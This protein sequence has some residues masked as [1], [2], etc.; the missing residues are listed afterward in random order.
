MGHTNRADDVCVFV[1]ITG[2]PTTI[3][4]Q[5]AM[6]IENHF[7]R[8]TSCARTNMLKQ[9]RN[10]TKKKENKSTK[11]AK[12]FINGHHKCGYHR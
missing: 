10:E 11:S 12:C 3:S 1:Y 6:R 7:V 4:I 2:L 8:R 9:K 5:I